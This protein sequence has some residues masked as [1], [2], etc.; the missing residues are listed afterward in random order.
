[1]FW[2]TFRAFSRIACNFIILV[3]CLYLCFDFVCVHKY[4]TI[5]N[6]LQYIRSYNWRSI[7][8]TK[9]VPYQFKET[10]Y[11]RA[12]IDQHADNILGGNNSI[13][14][15]Y[16]DRSY[17]VSKY[18]DQEY[19]PIH[20]ITIFTAA[21]GYTFK[22]RRSN[23]LVFNEALSIPTLDHSLINPNKLRHHQ[24]KVQE[25]PFCR[26]LMHIES[27]KVDIVACL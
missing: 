2:R 15:K 7:S 17:T 26:E 13:I 21:A 20:N 19:E 4:P 10:V 12:E 22:N 1:M 6:W 23:I 8:K 3:H 16:T 9:S 5:T 18:D 25:N 24:T 14:L 11:S 27:P